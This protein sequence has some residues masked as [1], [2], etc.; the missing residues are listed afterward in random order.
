MVSGET[1]DRAVWKKDVERVARFHGA[2]AEFLDGM[3][4]HVSYSTRARKLVSKEV[5]V[6]LGV[7]A[8]AGRNFQA[9]T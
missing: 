4:D 3:A 7:D 8:G 6:W 5:I 1:I 9:T 2:K